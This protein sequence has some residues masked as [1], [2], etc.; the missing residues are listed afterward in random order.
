MNLNNMTMSGRVVHDP[1]LR[2]TRVGHVL[3]VTIACERGYGDK[4]KTSFYIWTIWGKLAERFASFCQKGDVVE[5]NGEAVQE[6][7][8]DD[9]GNEVS[10]IKFTAKEF[11]KVSSSKKEKTEV[12]EL[13]KEETAEEMSNTFGID[14]SDIQF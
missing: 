2:E 4:A 9:R 6:V 14:E 7:Y 13:T 1:K 3:D 10:K 5:L 12:V 11:I 8:R